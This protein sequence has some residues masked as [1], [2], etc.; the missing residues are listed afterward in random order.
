MLSPI[1]QAAKGAWLLCLSFC[2]MPR[3]TATLL[4]SFEASLPAPL[5]NVIAADEFV[6]AEVIQGRCLGH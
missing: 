6:V 2:R 1:K 5:E 4:Q 3:Q